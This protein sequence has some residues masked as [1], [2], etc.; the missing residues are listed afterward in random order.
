VIDPRDWPL[1]VV[2]E[3]LPPVPPQRLRGPALRNWFASPPTWQPELL[4]DRSGLLESSRPAA[5]LVPIVQH[6]DAPTVLLTRRTAHLKRHSGQVAFPGGRKDEQDASAVATALREAREEVGLEPSHVEIIGTLPEYVTGT[7]FRVTPVIGL[8]EPG[9]DLTPDPNEVADIFEVPLEFLMNPQHHQ[10]RRILSGEDERLFFAM[11]W[12]C[13]R[14]EVEYFIWGATAA[15]LRNLYR[16]LSA[17][18]V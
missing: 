11:P 17:E 3:R 2:D 9:F 1:V 18:T 14:T 6:R 8:L 4:S 10:R 12:R 15:M 7:G 16:M 5:V 13:P